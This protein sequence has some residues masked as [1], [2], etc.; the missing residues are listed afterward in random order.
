M[1]SEII[2]A[3]PVVVTELNK[4]YSD[5][6]LGH[7]TVLSAT[8]GKRTA[9][10]TTKGLLPTFRSFGSS[11]GDGIHTEKSLNNNYKDI[12]LQMQNNTYQNV[13]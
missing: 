4:H 2:L 3:S 6:P 8:G 5:H 11:W 13:L 1:N 12:C 7:T 9:E 10:Q